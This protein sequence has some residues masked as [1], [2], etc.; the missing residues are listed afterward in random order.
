MSDF[1]AG[2]ARITGEYPAAQPPP[3]VS[4]S[5]P[6][7]IGLVFVLVG[8]IVTGAVKFARLESTVEAH[9]DSD[10]EKQADQ[11]RD[12]D[13]L[14]SKDIAREIQ[15]ITMAGDLKA[16]KNGVDDLNEKLDGPRQKKAR[17]R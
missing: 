11:R 4:H 15:I 3:P 10:K 17:P 5:T 8:A 13:A 7:T 16:V 9:I 14:K 12:I 6:I 2:T 1:Q